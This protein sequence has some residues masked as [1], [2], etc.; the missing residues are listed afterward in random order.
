MT[1]R[2]LRFW[3]NGYALV[4]STPLSITVLFN[5][6]VAYNGT[7]P[8]KFVE[9]ISVLPGDQAV[10]FAIEVPMSWSGTYPMTVTTDSPT[11]AT[12]YLASIDANFNVKSTNPAY[13][14]EQIAILKNPATTQS[15]KVA[16]LIECAD[17]SFTQ[18]EI[19]ILNSTDPEMKSVQ[20]DIIQ[21]HHL[22]L[23]LSNGADIYSSFGP[24][25][26]R[27]NVFVNGTAQSRGDD[28]PGGV[29]GYSCSSN[30]QVRGSLVCDV[31]ITAG[32]E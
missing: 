15:E 30:Q 4:G 16:I 26:P 17:P 18:E 22:T 28:P 5:N 14:A 1:A 24:T 23:Y 27:S 2:T 9:D 21:A 3:G 29:W 25:D 19:A 13:T 8:T 6:V 32:I 20:A 31:T 11:N 12:L 10:V 7:I